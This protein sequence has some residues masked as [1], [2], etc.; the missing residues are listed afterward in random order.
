MDKRL[1]YTLW[2]EKYRP[3][4]IR[5]LILPKATKAMFTKIV[6]EGEVPNL[7]FHSSNPGT[8]K[9]STAQCLVNEIGCDSLYINCSIETGIDTIRERIIG[10]ASCAS[11]DGKK[12]I[13]IC[14]EFDG[15]GMSAQKALRATIEEYHNFCRFIITCNYIT[16]IIEP[17]QSRCQLVDFNFTDAQVKEEML[18]KIQKRLEVVLK[19]EKVEY[20]KDLIPKIVSK[21]YADMR[22][23]Y[24]VCQQYS[25]EKNVIV[26]GILIYENISDELIELILTKKFTKAREFIINSNYSMHELYGVFFRNLVP[27]LDKDKRPEA[28]IL[29]ADYDF[30]SKTATDKE[31]QLCACLYELM[32]VIG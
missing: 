17:I 2:T 31:L 5:E 7:L 26:D 18:P 30:K 23:M 15:I 19:D 8:G 25:K 4:T 24:N 16:Q 10:F 20:N 6:S 32:G 21:Y 27:K 28:T 29:L 1:S 9:S 14:E 11:F 3:I 13:V 22:K 12:K